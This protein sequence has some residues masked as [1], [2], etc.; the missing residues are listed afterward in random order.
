MYCFIYGLRAPAVARA[1]VATAGLVACSD[2]EPTRI[3]A[4]APAEASLKLSSFAAKPGESLGLS[5]SASGL[6]G[7]QG[8]LHFDPSALTYVGQ[9][10]PTADHW[11]VVNATRAAQGELI[12]AALDLNRLTDLG[13][14]AFEV[15]S[16]NYLSGLRFTELRG[17]R[18]NGTAI[19]SVASVRLN[20]NWALG[21]AAPAD[22]RAWSPRDYLLAA[23]E[24]DKAAGRKAVNPDVA[25][26]PGFP[27]DSLRYGDAVQDGTVNITD[28]VYVINVSAGLAELII[29]TDADPAAV[30]P[31][32]F[33]LDAVVAGNVFPFAPVVGGAFN[34][35]E[36]TLDDALAVINEAVFANQPVVGDLVPGRTSPIGARPRA[37]RSGTIVTSQT[38]RKDSVY[39]LNG[40]VTIADGATLTIEPGTRIEGNSAQNPSAL[41]IDRKS[42]IVADGTP[43]EPIT[44]TCTAATKTKGCWGGVYVAGNAPQNYQVSSRVPADSLL[45]P[46]IAGRTTAG[47]LVQRG[48]GGNTVPLYG[49]CN[50]AD[51]SG[52]IRYAV[53]EFGG[54]LFSTANELN[55]LTLSGVGNRTIIDYVHVHAGQDDGL[56]IFG[57]SVNV[58][59]ILLTDNS[60]D[61][62]DISEGW[63]GMAQYVIVSQDFA[64]ADK[65]IESDGTPVIGTSFGPTT[66]NPWGMMGEVWNITMVGDRSTDP[67]GAINNSVNDAIHTR[68]GAMLS[69]RNGIVFGFRRGLRFD[70]NET[71]LRVAANAPQD[72]MSTVIK[73]VW[74]GQLY[75]AVGTGSAATCV[76]TLGANVAVPTTPSVQENLILSTQF[77]FIN[78]SR[79]TPTSP[80]VNQNR[81]V[82]TS[83]TEFP[84][85]GAS[86]ATAVV[87]NRP[88]AAR[89]FRT[90]ADWVPGVTAA[91]PTRRFTTQAAF[92]TPVSYPATAVTLDA[93]F[94][95]ATATFLGAVPPANSG[96]TNIP[97]YSGWSR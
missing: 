41:F 58:K 53:I 30:P 48:E 55:G 40:L 2:S 60:D 45:S 88:T 95:D 75:T 19:E 12:I 51:S 29:N 77:G 63:A 13:S 90:R 43:L 66:R 18:M 93:G 7:L 86:P 39:Q 65:G 73:N 47:C 91:T 76:D 87:F 15:K 46:A 72:T 14:L 34:A 23:W 21:A 17:T 11:M 78:S 54:F 3:E 38:W 20:S 42:Y 69:V 10:S 80:W 22:A 16:A 31:R 35:R 97:W 82:A 74:F 57:G 84:F 44:F 37:F 81:I 71:C 32:P 49:G 61:A 96:R 89:D 68:L 83:S 59:H 8:V 26:R 33:E 1:R 85:F 4:A 24:A 36:I 28:A 25:L 6:N 67:V 92:G 5:L 56:E 9:S 64:D 79:A 50:P 27:R 52:V 94:L 62:F 70:Y